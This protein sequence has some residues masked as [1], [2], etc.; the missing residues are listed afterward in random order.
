[1]IFT[2]K[3]RYDECMEIATTLRHAAYILDA[4]ESFDEEFV[5]DEEFD[6]YINKSSEALEKLSMI[7]RSKAKMYIEEVA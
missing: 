2:D 1:M 5:T 3:A 7:V 4:F 6:K